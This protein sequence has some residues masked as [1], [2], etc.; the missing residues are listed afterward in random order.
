HFYALGR[1]DGSFDSGME[2]LLE[3]LLADPKF[4]VR[5]E[6]EPPHVPS[7]TAY[8]VADLDLAARLSFFLWSSIPDEELL[9]LADSG[10]LGED[11][12]LRAQ[13]RRML[14]DPRASALTTNFADQWLGLRALAADTPVVSQFPDFDDNLRQAFRREVELLFDDLLAQDHS[15]VDLLSTDYTFVNGRLAEHYGIPG[16]RGSYFR[17]VKLDDSLSMRWGLIGKGALLTIS[18]SPART[19]PTIR[20]NWVLRTLIGVPAPDP[21]ADVPKLTAGPGDAAGNSRPPSMREQMVRHRAN[22]VC[23]SCHKIMDPIGF[24]LEPFDAIGHWRTEDN[25]NPIDT[26]SVLYDGAPVDGPAGVR[27]FLLR[28]QEQYLRNFTEALMTYALGR[29]IEYTDMPVVRS[30]LRTAG[31]NDY[32]IRSLVEAIVMSD[33]FRMNVAAGSPSEIEP[34]RMQVDPPGDGSRHG[35]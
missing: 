3:R 28:H 1:R 12:V 11:G 2:A 18:S 23:A 29:G 19:S 10:Q 5:V 33:L 13:V 35:S 4:L 25:G 15:P 34:L 21:P 22:A 30:V 8:R 26:R 24:A 27:A 9:R 6:T 16:V 7:G 20:G 32:R 31:R 14:A 17:R